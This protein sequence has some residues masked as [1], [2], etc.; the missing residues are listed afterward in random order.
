MRLALYNRLDVLEDRIESYSQLR[1]ARFHT[2]A[3][4]AYASTVKAFTVLSGDYP[5]D[6]LRV[7]TY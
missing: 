7:F 2:D 5:N 3:L 6:C 4:D 1:D